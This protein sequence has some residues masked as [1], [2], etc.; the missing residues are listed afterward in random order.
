M[1]DAPCRARPS[2]QELLVHIMIVLGTVYLAL[3]GF[4]TSRAA[5]M[6][7]AG[8]NSQMS[9]SRQDAY[10]IILF[11]SMSVKCINNDFRS[12]P[13]QLLDYLLQYK[14]G[15]GTSCSNA[16]RCAEEVMHQY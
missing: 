11:E 1:T 3:Y 15:G 7:T 4:W 16:V 8:Q 12:S 5:A 9:G 10:S 13:D 6:N 2:P 14:A